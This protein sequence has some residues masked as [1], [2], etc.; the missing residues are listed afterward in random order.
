MTCSFW[1]ARG[2]NANET[3]LFLGSNHTGPAGFWMILWTWWPKQTAVAG[4]VGEEMK[5][6]CMYT[7]YGWNTDGMFASTFRAQVL[8]TWWGE[9]HIVS[10]PHLK[11]VK[12]GAA[13]V[14]PS[15]CMKQKSC[16]NT[17]PCGTVPSFALH[18]RAGQLDFRAISRFVVY[19]FQQSYANAIFNYQ[20]HHFKYIVQP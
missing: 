16:N 4:I 1:A 8:S 17:M 2:D 19:S 3:Q 18:G 6:L 15:N 20:L 7:F 9:I 12:N 14:L 10:S 11:W 5:L 13:D